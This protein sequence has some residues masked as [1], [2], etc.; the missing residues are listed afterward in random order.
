MKLS[1]DKAEFE[2][3]GE[4]TMELIA[5][6]KLSVLVGACVDKK[7]SEDCISIAEDKDCHVGIEEEEENG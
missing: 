2:A 6:S 1:F 5:D 7:Q 4:E 3:A